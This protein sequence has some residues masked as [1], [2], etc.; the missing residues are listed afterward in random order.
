[1]KVQHPSF[2]RIEREVP[3]DRADGWL[4]AGWVRTED[5]AAQTPSAPARK[6]RTRR[7]KQS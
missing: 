6:P 7:K 3:D 5:E 2:P 1:M 4:A